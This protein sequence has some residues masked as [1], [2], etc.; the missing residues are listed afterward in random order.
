MSRPR[1]VARIIELL[2]RL[3][4]IGEKNATRLAHRLFE[5]PQEELDD[6]AKA[7]KE[8]RRTVTK[9]QVCFNLSETPVCHICSDPARDASTICVVEMPQEVETIER[10]GVYKGRYHVL[11]GLLTPS[12][13][14]GSSENTMDALA[15]RIE[16]GKP[17]ELI[18]ALSLDPEG[19]ATARYIAEMLAGTGVKVT[20]I[21]FGLP[22]AAKIEYADAVTIAH[23]FESKKEYS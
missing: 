5:W 23:A 21:G 19:E 3:P 7:L 17:K 11:W 2:S 12:G 14:K 18:L 9:C 22:A 1:A 16:E 15:K 13:A 6:F 10:A 8:L 20:R 4:G